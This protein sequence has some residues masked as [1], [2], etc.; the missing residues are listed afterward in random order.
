[1]GFFSNLINT[2]VKASQPTF[3]FKDNYLIFKISKNN[4]YTY[5]LN[6]YELKRRQDSCVSN[7]Y[8]IKSDEVFVE[9]IKLSKNASWNGSSLIFFESLFKNELKI[10]KLKILEEYEVNNYVLKTYEINENFVCFY[11]YIFNSSQD[12]FIIDTNGNLYKNILKRIKS[13]YVY[14]YEDKLKG[15]INFD[16]SLVKKNTLK[17]YFSID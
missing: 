1:M 17:D 8:T 5:N 7:A 9:Y 10:K 11:I 3:S 12:V 16:I 6:K 15:S 14:N 13:D 2:V 4:F